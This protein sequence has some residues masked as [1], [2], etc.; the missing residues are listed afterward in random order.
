MP[1]EGAVADG[2]AAGVLEAAAEVDEHVL[3]QVQVLAELAVEGRED[4]D[5]VVD[6]PAGEPAEEG[7]HLARVVR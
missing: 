4:G 3:A 1:D 5:R 6:R 7:A 2:D